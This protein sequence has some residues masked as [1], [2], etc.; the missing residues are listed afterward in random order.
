MD[1]SKDCTPCLRTLWSQRC[2]LYLKSY[3]LPF[4]F[5]SLT[6]LTLKSLIL[7]S[8]WNTFCSRCSHPH[9]CLYLPNV[10]FLTYFLGLKVFRTHNTFPC[11]SRKDKDAL[12]RVPT[13]LPLVLPLWFL[14]ASHHSQTH[15]NIDINC[16]MHQE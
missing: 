5:S 1:I 9:F 2:P 4:S 6:C 7:Y 15:H 3:N 8:Y 12:F 13:A 11:A 10:K 14:S 16:F